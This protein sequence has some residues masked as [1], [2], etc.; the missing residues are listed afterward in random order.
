MR[1]LDKTEKIHKIRFNYMYQ[2][3]NIKNDD[4]MV[5]FKESER[6]PWFDRLTETE[7]WISQEEEKSLQGAHI[8]APNTKWVLEDH[9]MVEV[10]RIEDP[11]QP[12][13]VRVGVLP[14]WLRY[15]KGMLG[16]DR[17]DD[18]LCVFR[19]IAVHQGA[20]KDRNTIRAHEL[21]E[22]FF[23]AHDIPN[24]KTT[25]R[26][27]SLIEKHFHQ[28]FAAYE[29]NEVVTFALKYL[30]SRFDKIGKPQM[31]IG[32]YKEHAF[33]ITNLDKVTHSYLCA[34]CQARFT[35]AFDLRRHA[36][37]CTRGVTKVKC[38][39]EKNQG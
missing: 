8:E 20:R 9:L 18:E 34:E 38:P 13:R 10:R 5:Y 31:N 16:L 23:A 32:I 21:A 4:T 19:C 39:G 27:F 2:L 30:P 1:R 35:Q 12:L 14:N 37:T 3:R 33:L 26:H 25:R 22:S 11:Q 6:S 29:V 15:K 24:R 17:Y 28:G 36:E 7:D